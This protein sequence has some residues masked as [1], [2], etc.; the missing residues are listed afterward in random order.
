MEDKSK[1]SE[2]ADKQSVFNPVSPDFAS[3]DDPAFG[4]DS[5]TGSGYSETERREHDGHSPQ[6]PAK[7]D[8][9]S[10]TE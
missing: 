4:S 5:T 3:A 9:E 6:I 2:P 8:D 10:A 1:N 7:P